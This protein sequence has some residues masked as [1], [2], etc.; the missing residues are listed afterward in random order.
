MHE[1]VKEGRRLLAKHTLSLDT[2]EVLEREIVDEYAK[3]N[4][5]VLVYTYARKVKEMEEGG[6]I[7]EH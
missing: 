7:A 2:G 4:T 6:N 3:P 5:R 1:L